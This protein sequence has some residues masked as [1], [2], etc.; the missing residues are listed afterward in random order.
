MEIGDAGWDILYAEY[1]AEIASQ[2]WNAIKA[3]CA[4]NLGEPEDGS[5][6]GSSYLGSVLSLAPS[7]KFYMP[8]T[9][10]QTEEDE[11]KDSAFYDALDSVAEE[12]GGY[13]LNGEDDACDLFFCMS[14]DKVTSE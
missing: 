7:G 13:I 2:D 12:Q 9:T 1:R 6:I 10:N 8:W 14:F 5:V 4:S 3:D 11:Y